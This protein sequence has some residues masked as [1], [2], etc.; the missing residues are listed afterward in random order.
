MVSFDLSS[1]Y[2]MTITDKEGKV[3]S[4]NVKITGEHVMEINEIVDPS[5]N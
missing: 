2:F 1:E 5:N 4:D 3:V